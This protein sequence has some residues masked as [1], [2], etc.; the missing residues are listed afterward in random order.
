MKAKRKQETKVYAKR[1]RDDEY[2][3]VIWWDTVWTGNDFK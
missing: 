3:D 2:W 1:W